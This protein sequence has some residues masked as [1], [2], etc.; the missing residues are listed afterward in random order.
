MVLNVL[1]ISAS[2]VLKMS[3]NI[4]VSIGC[5]IVIFHSYK[6]TESTNNTLFLK[7][8]FPEVEELGGN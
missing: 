5:A 7:Q 4:V 3:L 1:R 2:S 8:L 6:S